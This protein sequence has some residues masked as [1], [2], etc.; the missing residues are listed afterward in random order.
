MMTRW[1]SLLNSLI[2]LVSNDQGFGSWYRTNTNSSVCVTH[3]N[4]VC[5]LMFI[6]VDD[7]TVYNKKKTNISKTKQFLLP[8]L[9][10]TLLYRPHLERQYSKAKTQR[11]AITT[12]LI[13]THIIVLSEMERYNEM[14][15]W[16]S[17]ILVQSSLFT[18]P[19]FYQ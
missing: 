2:I 9:L 5:F 16:H 10:D 6:F 12:M 3:G 18:G 7:S 8:S 17:I 15:K 14:W 13:K 11:A 19:S 4:Y 1:L